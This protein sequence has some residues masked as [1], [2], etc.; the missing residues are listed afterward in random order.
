[1][2]SRRLF[3]FLEG[4]DSPKPYRCYWRT[5]SFANLQILPLL[6]KGHLVADLIALIGTIDIILGDVD[7]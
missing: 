7:R 4:N 5:P 6:A 1:M 3:V 2:T